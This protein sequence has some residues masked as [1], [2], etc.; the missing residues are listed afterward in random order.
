LVL[1]ETWKRRA[2]NVNLEEEAEGV[3]TGLAITR[4]EEGIE[5]Q[6]VRQCWRT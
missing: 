2:F 5:L 6:W 3:K 1:L 4:Q